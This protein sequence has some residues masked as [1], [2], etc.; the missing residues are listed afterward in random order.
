MPEFSFRRFVVFAVSQDGR[1]P[2]VMGD[3]DSREGAEKLCTSASTAS[4]WK[5]PFVWDSTQPWPFAK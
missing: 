1:K 3:A 2:G 4:Q 5:D